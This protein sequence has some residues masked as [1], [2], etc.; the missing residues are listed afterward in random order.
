[1]ES[2]VFF[3]SRQ[4]NTDQVFLVSSNQ[5]TFPPVKYGIPACTRNVT[6]EFQ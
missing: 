3:Q 6:S 1:M 2:T 5:K 4:A